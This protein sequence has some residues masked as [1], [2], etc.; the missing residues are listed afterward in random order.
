MAKKKRSFRDL[1]AL[2][3]IATDYIMKNMSYVVFL[4][5]LAVI[6]IANAHYSE[7]SIREIQSVQEE[8][9]Q[10]RWHYLSLKSDLMFDSKQSEIVK[11][12]STK[13]LKIA[14]K[15]LTKIIIDKE[16]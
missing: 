15:R 12:V 16:K 6:Y 8:L 4:S 1:T 13:E 3:S 5:F 7:K 10:L 2:G 9:E 14:D 11:D